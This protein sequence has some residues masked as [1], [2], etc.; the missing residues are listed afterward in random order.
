M[1]RRIAMTELN[2]DAS[3]PTA[4]D[5]LWRIAQGVMD[6]KLLAKEALRALGVDYDTEQERLNA[7]NAES[8][9]CESLK[10]SNLLLALNAKQARIDA[11]MME[12]CPGEMSAA[13][14]AEWARN[15]RPVS[16]AEQEDPARV[17]EDDGC[18]TEMAVLKRFW[19][20][21]HALLPPENPGH[22]SSLHPKADAAHAP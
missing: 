19:R 9:G 4:R 22:G 5:A 20:A 1:N 11:L 12:F 3:L 13:Q 15:Q 17:T 18:P 2:V 21:K 7:L 10:V 6:P 16:P 14:R 8:V